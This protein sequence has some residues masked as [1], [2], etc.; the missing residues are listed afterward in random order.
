VAEVGKIVQSN[1]L[2]YLCSLYSSLNN[3]APQPPPVRKNRSNFFAR[4]SHQL[5]SSKKTAY[6]IPYFYRINQLH[7]LALNVRSLQN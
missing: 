5:G 1:Y 3:W 6:S 4:I 2:L 7:A